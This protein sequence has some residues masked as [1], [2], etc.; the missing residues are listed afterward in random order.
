[1]HNTC[2]KQNYAFYSLNNARVDSIDFVL[3]LEY[4]KILQRFFINVMLP[5]KS[6][7]R[8]GSART[9][10]GNREKDKFELQNEPTEQRFRVSCHE[11]RQ[12]EKESPENQE[13][14]HAEER[15]RKKIEKLGIGSRRARAGTC[16]KNGPIRLLMY[17]RAG[18]RELLLSLSRDILA[19]YSA[20]IN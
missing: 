14:A 12:N 11:E 10:K 16:T 6:Y 8:I 15:K 17:S 1:M 2:V 19:H 9:R 5:Q 13:A 4:H 7:T 18:S 20:I 3:Y